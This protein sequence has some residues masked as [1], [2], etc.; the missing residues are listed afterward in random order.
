MKIIVT[1]LVMFA[2]SPGWCL[3]PSAPPA[4]FIHNRAPPNVVSALTKAYNTKSKKF[5]LPM[6]T[7]EG[8][9]AGDIFEFSEHGKKY[10]IKKGIHRLMGRDLLLNNVKQFGLKNIKFPGK[11]LYH[12]QGSSFELSDENYRVVV[13][14]IAFKTVDFS[15]LSDDVAY[16]LLLMA[17]VSI[18][19]DLHEGNVVK[20]VD[21]Y[22]IIDTEP[23]EKSLAAVNTRLKSF[24]FDKLSVEVQNK[25]K[26][27]FKDFFLTKHYPLLSFKAEGLSC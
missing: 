3:S 6:I 18:W 4:Y 24:F 27:R 14:K 10:L 25:L 16:D 1:C 5:N 8:K 7:H 19:D 15:M 12:I 9:S 13:E 21:A 2:T 20:A 17:M 22:Y 11:W 23:T 26:C